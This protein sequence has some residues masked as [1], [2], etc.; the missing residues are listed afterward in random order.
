MSELN[1]PNSCNN[2]NVNSNLKYNV[3]LNTD[4]GAPIPPGDRTSSA[5]YTHRTQTSTMFVKKSIKTHSVACQLS[6]K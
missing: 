5:F 2:N 4:T 3:Q 6:V 1:A